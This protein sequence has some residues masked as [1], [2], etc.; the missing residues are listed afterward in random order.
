MKIIQ[1]HINSMYN[2]ARPGPTT[3]AHP[4]TTIPRFYIIA[5]QRWR[6]MCICVYS[7]QIK[8]LNVIT[9]CDSLDVQESL[10]YWFESSPP[11]QTSRPRTSLTELRPGRWRYHDAPSFCKQHRIRLTWILTS[12]WPWLSCSVSNGWV[13]TTCSY[14]YEN[15]FSCILRKTI[16][17]V[18]HVTQ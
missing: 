17:A 14:M 1:Q 16:F 3:V 13:R 4:Q 15:S 10:F 5:Q 2:Q 7:K 6:Q 11:T 12:S 18:Y 9:L 8:T